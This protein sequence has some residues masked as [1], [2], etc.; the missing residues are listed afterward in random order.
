MADT[1]RAKELPAT[2]YAVL[3]L[4]SFGETS[5]YDLKR[6]ADQSIG[7]FF[8][9]PATSQVYSEL[10]RLTSLGYVREREV[11]QERRPDKRLYHI[12]ADG[13]QAL[14]RWLE[15]PEVPPDNVKSLFLLKL[16]FGRLTP[17]ETLIGQLEQLRSQAQQTLTEFKE[18]ERRIADREDK[19]FPHLTLK[20]RIAY[21]HATQE[22]AEDAL[23]ELDRRLPH[24]VPHE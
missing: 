6:F 3:G 21:V 8:W 11:A 1:A 24:E 5:G 20:S 22:W 2:S 13:E 16:F 23:Q 17:V 18:I 4:V 14:R 9:S 12:T 7:Y 15:R 19:F 10:R